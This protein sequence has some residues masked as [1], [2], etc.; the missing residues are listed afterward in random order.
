ML[1]CNLIFLQNRIFQ[2]LSLLLLLS[3]LSITQANATHVRAG[4]IIAIRHTSG[5]NS[6]TFRYRFIFTMYRDTCPTCVAAGPATLYFGYGSPP[7]NSGAMEPI[8]R[9]NIGNETER[10][11]YEF[12]HTYPAAGIYRVYVTVDNRNRDV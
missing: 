9:R 5:G 10:V 6:N 8:E 12:T 4:E 1:P 7:E 3:I 2:A 11:T